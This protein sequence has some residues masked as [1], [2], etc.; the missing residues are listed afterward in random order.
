MI[1]GLEYFC[2]AFSTRGMRNVGHINSWIARERRPILNMMSAPEVQ[3]VFSSS[4]PS[5]R[6][7]AVRYVTELQKKG[8]YSLEHFLVKDENG[9]YTTA[10]YYGNLG[11]AGMDTRIFLVKQLLK[12]SISDEKTELFTSNLFELLHEK[13]SLTD[14]F[15]RKGLYSNPLP[16]R[17]LWPREVVLNTPKACV[18]ASEGVVALAPDELKDYMHRYTDQKIKDYTKTMLYF[19]VFTRCLSANFS[20]Q[21]CHNGKADSLVVSDYNRFIGT[22]LYSNM[23]NPYAEAA[24][25]VSSALEFGIINNLPPLH[26]EILFRAHRDLLNSAKS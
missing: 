25:G 5:S 20:I 26:L 13:H 19:I 15:L 7:V 2:R 1:S 22:V 3:E 12:P 24:L 4:V 9:S 11:I 8:F 18:I 14:Q 17:I 16:M 6:D 21:P 10:P 23:D